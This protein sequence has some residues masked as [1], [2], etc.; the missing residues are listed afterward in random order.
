M[1]SLT[2]TRRSAPVADLRRPALLALVV[3]LLLATL[4]G[5]TLSASA[6]EGDAR[7]Q[8]EK[9][10]ADKAQVASE[11]DALQADAAQV[12]Q[13]LADLQADVTT[14]RAALSD[15][16]RALD[17]AQAELARLDGEIAATEGEIAALQDELRGFAVAAYVEPPVDEGFGALDAESA[18]ASAQKRVFLELQG[19]TSG[20][21]LDQLRGAQARLTEQRGTAEQVRAEA[22]AHRGEVAGRTQ[23]VESA[24]QRQAAFNAQVEARLNDRLAEAQSLAA[25]DSQLSDQIAAEEAAVAARLAAARQREADEAARRAAAARSAASTPSMRPSTGSTGAAPSTTV[26]TGPVVKPPIVTSGSMVT[27]GGITV[28]ASIAS[29]LQGLLGAASASG[30]NLGGT[31]WRDSSAQIALRMQHC[32]S[33]DYAIY[34]MSP[35]ACSPPTAIPGRSKHEQGLAVDFTCNGQ[36]IQS[37]SSACFQWMAA[38]AGSFGWVNLPSEPWHWSVGGG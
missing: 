4:V 18:E 10:R 32:G 15:A 14:Q 27:V 22:E 20:N 19:R 37:R 6:Q 3:A 1:V 2:R 36:M 26:P 13:A 38:N 29:N 30:I 12:A 23:Q 17:S 11:V 25:L 31:G 5:P 35:D 8:R 28:N 9:V 33:S 21:V 7:A 16:Q 24:Y 34:Q